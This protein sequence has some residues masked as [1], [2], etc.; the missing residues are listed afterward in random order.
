M[1]PWSGEHRAFVVEVYFSSGFSL[2]ETRRRFNNHYGIRR[3]R[4]GPSINLIRSWVA[5]F[6]AT[7]STINR[8]RPG[9][10]PTVA[11]D[12]NVE[13]VMASVIENPRLSLRARS[14]ILGISKSTLQVIM[15]K[16]L[17]LHP[18]KIQIVQDLLES[19]FELRKTY[20]ETM[21]LRF[22]TAT[23]MGNIFFSDEAHFHIGGYVNKQNF[24]YWD[25]FNPRK[26]HEEPLHKPKVTVWCAI[27]AS[28]IIGPY[29]F[30]NERGQT[31]TVNSERYAEMI[32]DFFRLELQNSPY[33]NR[34]TWFQQDGATA[35]TANVAMSAVRELFP[36]KIISRNGTIPWP[37]RS[38]DLSPCDF[39]LWGYLKSIVYKTNPTTVTQLKENIRA[40]ISKIPQSLCKRVFEN[41]RSRLE[42]CVRV[43]G[44]HLE[45]V[46]FKK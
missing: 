42:E 11:T 35:H 45:N 44:R 15:R 18:Y 8:P 24:R 36:E 26:L 27:S 31:V 37:P 30:E 17:K 19:D 7:G 33:C 1:D 23:R 40:E 20:A 12:E 28:A 21:L 32:S 46:V 14:S 43:D 2:S 25:I 39:F 41:M 5:R 6:R 16:K 34:N 3:I 38:P 13:R 22:K 9:P 10:T 4:D 29:F